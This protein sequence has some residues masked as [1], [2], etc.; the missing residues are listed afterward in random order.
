V[1]VRSCTLCEPLPLGA[2][3]IIQLN[4]EARILIA[5]QAPGRITHE[6]GIPFDDPSGNRLRAWMGVDREIFYDAEKIAIVPMGFC[7]PGAGKGGDLAPRTECAER[8]RQELLAMLTNIELTLVIGR[9]AMDWHL[10]SP[11]MGKTLTHTVQ[12]WQE[13]WPDVLPMP[14]PSPRN[15]RWLKNNPWFESDILPKLKSRVA[16]LIAK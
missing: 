16:S 13:F 5:G 4:P 12:N 6:K 7:F 8:W 14:H 1:S 3:P 15:Q 2:K 11:A 9:Y 10:G